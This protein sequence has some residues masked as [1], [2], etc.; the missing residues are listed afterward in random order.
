MKYKLI[1]NLFSLIGE[2]TNTHTTIY[3]YIY[4]CLSEIEGLRQF[5]R[6]FAAKDWVQ[7]LEIK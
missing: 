4:I 1:I 5:W 6:G 3:I 7:M 2:Q